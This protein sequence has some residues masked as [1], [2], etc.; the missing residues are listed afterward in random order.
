MALKCRAIYSVTNS[1]RAAIEVAELKCAENSFRQP[2]QYIGDGMKIV[3][4]SLICSLTWQL[5]SLNADR[6]IDLDAYAAVK[7][8]GSGSGTSRPEEMSN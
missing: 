4:L 1:S 2:L 5:G 6:L 8:S 3:V 7:G